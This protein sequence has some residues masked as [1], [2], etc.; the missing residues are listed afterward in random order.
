M[1]LKLT[2]F[3]FHGGRGEPARLALSIGGIEELARD[4]SCLEIDEKS[5]F[6]ALDG[7]STGTQVPRMWVLLV[8][9]RFGGANHASGHNN[10]SPYCGGRPRSPTGRS[11]ERKPH[12]RLVPVA[13]DAPEQTPSAK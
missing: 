1:P 5:A 7:S 2:Y 11:P 6:D 13:E 8:L 10:R 9:P 3:D 12:S 4:H